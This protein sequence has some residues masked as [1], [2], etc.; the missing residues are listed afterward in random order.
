MNYG[1]NVDVNVDTTPLLQGVWRR[2]R[3]WKKRANH[4]C[5]NQVTDGRGKK[6]EAAQT[7]RQKAMAILVHLVRAGEKR[8]ASFPS[9][10]ALRA[11]IYGEFRIRRRRRRR[12]IFWL[13]SRLVFYVRAYLALI[14]APYSILHLCLL[15]LLILPILVRP[16]AASAASAPLCSR[17]NFARLPRRLAPIG[18][19]VGADHCTHEFRRRRRRRRSLC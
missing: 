9:P 17:L 16:S 8:S 2:R 18:R 19:R 13:Q 3:R 5:T 1:A 7:D 11:T 4:R 14:M 12:R 15:L 6:G 10:F